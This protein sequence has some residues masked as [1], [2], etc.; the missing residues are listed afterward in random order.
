VPAFTGV[1]NRCAV[2]YSEHLQ[3]GRRSESLRPAELREPGRAYG[4]AKRPL[5]R[6]A[7]R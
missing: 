3:H 4:A 1:R 6:A 2:L 7:R 5:A